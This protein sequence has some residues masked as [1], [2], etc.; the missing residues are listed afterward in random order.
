[1]IRVPNRPT[2]VANPYVQPQQV[3]DKVAQEDDS[4]STMAAI[5]LVIGILFGLP[6][7][8][9]VLS[10]WLIT[11]PDDTIANA[12]AQAG[13]A[14]QRAAYESSM[15]S[16]N[17]TASPAIDEARPMLDESSGSYQL[18]VDDWGGAGY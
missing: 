12:H 14:M 5:G 7:A 10:V 6:L 9:S 11:P 18:D 17:H 3:D 1:M 8:I 4:R 13:E 15:D 16:W 2:P